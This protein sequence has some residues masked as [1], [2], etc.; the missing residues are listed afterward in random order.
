VLTSLDIDTRSD[1]YALGVLLY[2]LL[3]GQTP[4]DAKQLLAIGLDE[5][6]RTIREQEPPPPSSRLSTLPGQELSTTAQRRG[7]DAPKL[8][9]EL[10][11]DLDWIVMKC[12]EKDRARRYETA[13]GLALDIQRHLTNEPIVAR[14]PSAAY[15]FQKA[16]RRN[17]MAFIA[18]GAVTCALLLGVVAS[19]W[20]AVRA[21][22]AE[23][24]Q[25]ASAESARI[26]RDVAI[27]AQQREAQ[28]REETRQL[29]YAS[30]ME[31]AQHAWEANNVGLVLELL[32]RHKDRKR[33]GDFEWYYL[34]RL[35]N[36]SL[37]TPTIQTDSPALGVALSPDGKTLAYG[38]MDGSVALVNIST[39]QIRKLG[40]H[41][42]QVF[43]VAFSPDGT[44]LASSSGDNTVRLWD[45]RTAQ[46]IQ[47][48]TNYTDWVRSVDFS[49][50][51]KFLAVGS[52][53]GQVDL[54]NVARREFEWRSEDSRY[55]DAVAFSPDGTIIA[56][57]NQGFQEPGIPAGMKLRD[58]ATGRVL[59]HSTARDDASPAI[60]FSPDGHS[61]AIG[62]RDGAIL[63]FDRELKMVA[64]LKGHAS[65]VQSLVYLDSNTLAS[66]SSDNTVRL[67]DLATH[68]PRDTLKGHSGAVRVACSRDGKLLV[69]A[70]IDHTV[71]LWD[72][73]WQSEKSVLKGH[74]S[75]VLSVALSPDGSTVASGSYDSTVKLWDAATGELKRNLQGHSEGVTCIA[76]SP[77]GVT[78][79][80]SGDDRTIILWNTTTGEVKR[81]L[82]GH[83]D[84]LWSLA[85]LDNGLTLASAGEDGTVRL[86]SLTTG[87]GRT[88]RKQPGKIGCL[89]VWKDQALAFGGWNDY[90]IELW[91]LHAGAQRRE[92]R[93]H[94]GP[95][96]AM[97]FM[98][99]GRE[100]VTGSWDGTVRL[101]NLDSSGPPEILIRHTDS[102][103]AVAVSP[104]G[105]TL[106]CGANDGAVKLLDLSTRRERAAL[107]GHMGTV[108]S[109]AFS[110]DGKL[111]VSGG[112]DRTVRLW[113][114]ATDEEVARANVSSMAAR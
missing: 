101:W 103:F 43:C 114:A 100:L 5:M 50:D 64:E 8:V 56:S 105:A 84:T 102:I 49:P 9:S 98:S 26:D 58:A 81:R 34:W 52:L 104:D 28:A 6:R 97:M 110:K 71:R 32:E 29:L 80:S 82:T 87:E 12:L 45:M 15:K 21:T 27:A 68:S 16:W 30:D 91:D 109:L 10:R 11:G 36:R 33:P 107:K 67:W 37:L 66:G 83:T 93:G 54:W 95:V 20:Q 4:F 69:S 77:D 73:D 41:A 92:L 2:E 35:C 23:K 86:W 22:V 74:E 78:L 75:A 85:F 79:A 89:S 108:W 39:R 18:V 46:Q 112:G 76:F 90:F 61:L 31:R 99:T 53:D 65:A 3:T 19:I 59:H 70:S 1:I 60:K 55:V 57:A 44:L 38:G 72:L 113:R 94:L 24:A 62:S 111:L 47:Q 13:N 51:G 96:K 42:S 7:L 17:R 25:K 88:L 106:A 14:P 48:I 63:L 40:T